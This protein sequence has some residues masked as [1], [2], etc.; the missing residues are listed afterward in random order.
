MYGQDYLSQVVESLFVCYQIGFLLFYRAV[1]IFP[2]LLADLKDP[3]SGQGLCPVGRVT[4]ML[5]LLFY[6]KLSTN[7]LS[8]KV[9][10][11]FY[12]W[13]DFTKVFNTIFFSGIISSRQQA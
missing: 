5:S 8:L 3:K 1:F 13:L 10:N 12:C 7:I 6:F 11:M 9:V 4:Y 2:T